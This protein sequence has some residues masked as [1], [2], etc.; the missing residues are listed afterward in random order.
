ML[1]AV[2]DTAINF[3][4][5]YFCN[6]SRRLNR[7]PFYTETPLL[8]LHFGHN[9]NSFDF[10]LQ[11]LGGCSKSDRLKAVDLVDFWTPKFGV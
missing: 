2:P 10:G 6:L 11:I 9:D 7:A 1:I 5:T 3:G 8:K 4:P